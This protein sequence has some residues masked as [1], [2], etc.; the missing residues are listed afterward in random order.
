[1]N[2]TILAVIAGALVGGVAIAGYQNFAT[3]YADVVSATPITEREPIYGDVLQA[4]AVTQTVTGSREVCQDVAVERRQPERFGNK[5]GA[6]IGALVGGLV[7][8]QVGG[9]DG[10][11][12]ATVAGAVGGGFAGREIDRRHVGGQRYTTTEK[13]CHTVTEPRQ[14]VIGYDVRYQRDGQVLTTRVDEKPGAQILL[15]ERD[16]IVGYEVDWKYKD[17]TGTVIMDE[18]PGDRLPME[19]GTIAIRDDAGEGDVDGDEL[20]TQG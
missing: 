6:V 13:Q 4:D 7:G 9:G 16:R 11:K 8:S 10:K 14:E 17:Q 12:L 3:P 18:K 1:M 5:D 15:G 19:N 2:K 20:P